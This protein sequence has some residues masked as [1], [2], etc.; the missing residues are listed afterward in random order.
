[1][2]VGHPKTIRRWNASKIHK[3]KA[4]Q[5]KNKNLTENINKRQQVIWIIVHTWK[6]I[7]VSINEELIIAYHVCAICGINFGILLETFQIDWS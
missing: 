2:P 7:F 6:D 4:L 1:M 5:L 3:N